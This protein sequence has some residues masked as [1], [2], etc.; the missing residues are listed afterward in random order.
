MTLQELFELCGNRPWIILAY[1]LFI[2]FTALLASILGKNEGHLSPWKY[3]YSA[4]VYMVSI[5]GLFAVIL[6]IYL[7]L[8]ER[9]PIME[10]D[11]YSQIL[12]ILSM[13]GTLL[14][15]KANVDLDEVPGFDRLTAF[16]MIVSI[17]MVIM[18]ILD[19]THLIAFTFIPFYYVLLILLALI[20]VIRVAWKKMAS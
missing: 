9:R 1:F 3:L 4:L 2:P 6:N 12:P 14:L 20:I 17:I 15:I 8:F 7:F 16:L 5:P 19:K 18:W 10:T 13:V 11:I